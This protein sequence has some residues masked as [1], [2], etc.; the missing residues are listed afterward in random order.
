MHDV[1]YS[2]AFAVLRHYRAPR[3]AS[4][5]LHPYQLNSL[6]SATRRATRSLSSSSTGKIIR[7]LFAYS[8]QDDE[9]SR[10]TESASAHKRHVE[11]TL[12]CIRLRGQ[13]ALGRKTR[14]AIRL[15][16]LLVAHSRPKSYQSLAFS[17]RLCRARSPCALCRRIHHAHSWPCPFQAAVLD[18][19]FCAGPGREPC[20]SSIEPSGIELNLVNLYS[21]GECDS[22]GTGLPQ[23]EFSTSGARRAVAVQQMETPDRVE[24]RRCTS[25]RRV[26]FV[27]VRSHEWLP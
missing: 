3:R 8:A 11:K 14:L 18:T 13:F 2:H 19:P 7:H 26:C 16:R 5:L 24:K 6:S 12:C 22:V 17:P 10:C 23:G 1:F 20:L 4:C 21:D 27:R 25:L 9:E 15:V